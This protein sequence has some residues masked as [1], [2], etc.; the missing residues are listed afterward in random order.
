MDKYEPVIAKEQL[1]VGAYYK[2][3][4]RNANVARWN[5]RLFIHWREKFTMR[6]LEEIKCP[7]DETHF[8]VFIAER[9][10]TQEEVDALAHNGLLIPLEI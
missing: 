6:F 2:G 4:C 5:G 9:K 7:E 8:D 1:E 3:R 10:M